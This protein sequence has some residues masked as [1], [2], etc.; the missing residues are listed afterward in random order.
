MV[1]IWSWE[2]KFWGPQSFPNPNCYIMLDGCQICMN[3]PR[4]FKIWCMSNLGDWPFHKRKG[5]VVGLVSEDWINHLVDQ[6]RND[7]TWPSLKMALYIQIHSSGIFLF[8]NTHHSKG[9]T[10]MYDKRG[11]HKNWMIWRGN[12]RYQ[13]D[14]MIL[15]CS[16]GCP[17]FNAYIFYCVKIQGRPWDQCQVNGGRCGWKDR[18][19][20]RWSPHVKFKGEQKRR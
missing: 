10:K 19:D 8:K 18:V 14:Q 9:L 6:L 11:R 5:E 17:N 20:H 15:S 2:V 12:T 13:D 3:N 7:L 4:A 1:I 16:F